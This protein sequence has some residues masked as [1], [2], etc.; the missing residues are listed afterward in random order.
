[1]P[2]TRVTAEL[3]TYMLAKRSAE[4]G[5]YATFKV[6]YTVLFRT[7]AVSEH[8]VLRLIL[9]SECH[10][11]GRSKEKIRTEAISMVEFPA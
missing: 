4:L 9:G 1:M 10:F 11:Q 3:V 8:A 5:R 6:P 7:S 2:S